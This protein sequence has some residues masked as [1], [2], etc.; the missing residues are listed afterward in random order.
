LSPLLSGGRRIVSNL[1]PAKAELIRETEVLRGRL[2]QLESEKLNGATNGK[3][4]LELYRS[5]H[6]RIDLVILDLIMP[7]MG[8]KEL[9]AEIRKM[10]RS[11]KV[12]V[13]TGYAA[14]GSIEEVQ[15]LG[16]KVA[17]RKPFRTQE[18]LE[19]IRGS[20]STA[21]RDGC[22]MLAQGECMSWG[23]SRDVG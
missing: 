11:A 20:L 3:E 6:R 14:D 10:N 13:T 19:A 23:I 1:Y 9:L 16:A 8:G 12:V 2:A 7:E 15:K 22:G 4:G 21:G 17:I 18:L 5:E